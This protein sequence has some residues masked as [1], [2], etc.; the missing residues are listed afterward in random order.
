MIANV[1]RRKGRRKSRRKRLVDSVSRLMRVLR[2]TRRD[3][4]WLV[5]KGKGR[6]RVRSRGVFGRLGG[7]VWR[8]AFGLEQKMVR[9]EGKER[10]MGGLESRRLL[11]GSRGEDGER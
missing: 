3:G 1:T 7:L 10:R 5:M 4:V 8:V 6:G 9:R 11:D 2:R